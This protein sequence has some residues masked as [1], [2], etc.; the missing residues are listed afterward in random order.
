MSVGCT[1]HRLG[2]GRLKSGD[3]INYAVGVKLHA[4]VGDFLNEG[5]SFCSC[6]KM[7][8]FC[9]FLALIFLFH[10]RIN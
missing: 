6:V 10:C 8:S 7:F 1:A 2:A 4:Q 5:A 3:P 9:S